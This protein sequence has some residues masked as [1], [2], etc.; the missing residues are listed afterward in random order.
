MKLRF[1]KLR[2]QKPMVS[3]ISLL[4]AFFDFEQ[5]KVLILETGS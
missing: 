1:P 2:P 5:K 3:H 4:K